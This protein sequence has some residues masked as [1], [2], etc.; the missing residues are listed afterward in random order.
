MPSFEKMQ[1]MSQTYFL[2]LQVLGLLLQ[3]CI[4]CIDIATGTSSITSVPY[5]IYMFL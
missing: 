2:S 5:S 4:L 1:V 3:L